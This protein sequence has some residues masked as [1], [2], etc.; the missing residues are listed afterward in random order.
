MT[1]NDIHLLNRTT[2]NY[3]IT[4]FAEKKI[5]IQYLK[6]YGKGPRLFK[7]KYNIYYTDKLFGDLC[8]PKGRKKGQGSIK[9]L[10][11]IGGKRHK[12]CK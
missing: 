2:G 9:N 11:L 7:N 5:N 10:L 12:Y 1:D 3:F 8:L 4:L 6:G